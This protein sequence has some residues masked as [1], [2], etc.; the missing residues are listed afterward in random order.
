[1][2][3][4]G[5]RTAGSSTRKT[6]MVAS[7]M[8]TRPTSTLATS[9]TIAAGREP[10]KLAMELS[11]SSARAQR[12][13]RMSALRVL[14]RAFGRS[15]SSSRPSRSAAAIAAAISARS[16]LV[17]LTGALQARLDALAQALQRPDAR[18][19]LA[20]G[21][22]HV[23]RRGVRGRALDHVVHRALVLR[24]L[25]AVAPVLGRDLEALVGDLL[26]R[27]EAPELL[28][29]RDGHPELGDD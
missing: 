3:S 29:R 22:D 8:R 13:S 4:V 16:R 26:A 27:A 21:G 6:K 15:A 14:A 7:R 11:A 12:P 5:R 25:L 24:P 18:E 17:M 28:L 10:A 20:V 1:M 19:E 23:P 9:A 2:R